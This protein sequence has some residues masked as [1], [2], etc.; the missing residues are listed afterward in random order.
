M[1]RPNV[2]S[3][4]TSELNVRTERPSELGTP[5]VRPFVRRNSELG[6]NDRHHPELTCRRS[7]ES[8]GPAEGR[9]DSGN[10]GLTAATDPDVGGCDGEGE[11]S[12]D[13]SDDA[14]V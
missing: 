14:S 8:S 11:E 3:V 5:S 7:T 1:L 9:E 6:T 13:A 10:D 2:G 4:Q 12:S